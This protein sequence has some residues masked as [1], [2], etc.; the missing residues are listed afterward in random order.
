MCPPEEV[1][2]E[3]AHNRKTQAPKTSRTYPEARV[4]ACRSPQT[5]TLAEVEKAVRVEPTAV[6][7]AS[8][9]AGAVMVEAEEVAS[10]APAQIGMESRQTA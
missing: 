3:E 8:V 10:S 4:W 9:V 1:A 2:E 7:A 6:K 5:G